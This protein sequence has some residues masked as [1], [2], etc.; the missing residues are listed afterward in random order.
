MAH[1]ALDWFPVST[2]YLFIAIPVVL[3]AA[4][5]VPLIRQ[6][7]SQR[8]AVLLAAASVPLMN[9]LTPVSHDYKL[10]LLV[11]PLAVLIALL[12]GGGSALGPPLWRSALGGLVALDAV[13]LHGSTTLWAY[14]SK[15]PL[16]VLVQVLLLIVV[17]LLRRG[18]A[19]GRERALPVGETPARGEG[20]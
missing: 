15:Y 12:F 1:S 4:T 16:I 8:G 7:W 19:L 5:A 6:G 20:G 2:E 3:W 18:A 17:V 13:A 14:S 9:V 10:V 11:F